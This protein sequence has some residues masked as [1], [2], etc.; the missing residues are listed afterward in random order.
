MLKVGRVVYEGANDI[1]GV[2]ETLPIL[3][4]PDIIFHIVPL[5]YF[6]IFIV[7]SYTNNPASDVDTFKLEVF[8]LGNNIPLSWL[9]I[10]NTEYWLGVDVFIPIEPSIIFD[11]IYNISVSVVLSLYLPINVISFITA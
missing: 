6:N 10:S 7:L 1:V 4:T 3:L 11:F 2:K 8:N 9:Y 5:K